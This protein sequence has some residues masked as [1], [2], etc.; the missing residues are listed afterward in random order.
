MTGGLGLSLKVF[1]NDNN[2]NSDDDNQN[3][4]VV[5]HQALSTSTNL[6]SL[7]HQLTMTSVRSDFTAAGNFG[8]STAAENL[9]MA[10][11]FVCM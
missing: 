8:D 4:S 1:V 6:M 7:A 10:V 3:E 11:I 2:N 5:R 9:A